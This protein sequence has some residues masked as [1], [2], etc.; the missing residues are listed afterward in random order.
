MD[1][2]LIIQTKSATYYWNKD[3]N[4]LQEGIETPLTRTDTVE[5]IYLHSEKHATLPFDDLYCQ[6]IAETLANLSFT[7]GTWIGRPTSIQ[8]T[9]G[10][11]ER[12]EARCE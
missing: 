7:R 6:P 5:I 4:V 3:G 9:R 1:R 8:T 12:G 11:S 10:T 2:S